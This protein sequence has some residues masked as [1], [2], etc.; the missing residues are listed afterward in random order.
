MKK[1]VIALF[2]IFCISCINCSFMSNDDIIEE[3]KKCKDA[4][5]DIIILKNGL[6]G[7]VRAVVCMPKDVHKE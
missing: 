7:D 5:M 4:D 3:T 1:L 2:C 6:S